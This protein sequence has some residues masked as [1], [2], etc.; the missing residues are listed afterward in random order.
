MPNR[1]IYIVQTD[2]YDMHFEG[3]VSSI[4]SDQFCRL[5][6]NLM[7][8]RCSSQSAQQSSASWTLKGSGRKHILS[9]SCQLHPSANLSQAKYYPESIWKIW[10]KT[11]R[12]VTLCAERKSLIIVGELNCQSLVVQSITLLF[13]WFHRPIYNSRALLKRARIVQP[14]DNFPKF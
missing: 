9:I 6:L 2:K 13:Y 4:C 1:I 10:C 5:F 11:K 14:F 8:R 7:M 3:Q 12:R